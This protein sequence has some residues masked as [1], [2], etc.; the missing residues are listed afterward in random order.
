MTWEEQ[1][2]IWKKGSK[3]KVPSIT[4]VQTETWGKELW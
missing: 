1:L 3:H 4:E 2:K